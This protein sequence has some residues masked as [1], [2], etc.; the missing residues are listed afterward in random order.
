MWKQVTVKYITNTTSFVV[1]VVVVVVVVVV[2]IITMTFM[3]IVIIMMMTKKIQSKLTLKNLSAGLQKQ[4]QGRG[5]L[6]P[7]AI[8]VS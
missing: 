2:V 7:K 3:M 1:M 5:I 8:N 6:K 4:R